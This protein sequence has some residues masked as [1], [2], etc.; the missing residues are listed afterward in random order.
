[1]SKRK[2][3]DYLALSARI[4][5][6]ENRLLTEERM[7]RMIDAKDTEDAAKVLAECGYGALSALTG[8]GVEQMLT[9]AQAALFRELSGDEAARPV[10]EV[11]RCKYD[12]HNAKALVKAAAL[13]MELSQAE[14]ILLPGG[15][16]DTAALMEGFRR[17]EL[18]TYSEIFRKG[19]SQAQ[20]TL[21]ATGD[22]QLA[23]LILDRAYFAELT[24]L[25]KASGS[26]FLQGYAAL[27]IDG[28]NLRSAVRAARLGKGRDFLSQVLLPGGN[29]SPQAVAAADGRGLDGVFRSGALREAA[30]AGATLAAPGSGPLTDFERLCD[31]AVMDYLGGGRR[32]PFGEQPV[33]GYLHAREAEMTAV[34]TI[35]NGRLAGLPG[36]V[37]RR[38]LRRPYA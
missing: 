30:A 23:D 12:Y 32:V 36:E 7:E 5:A 21:G 20:E 26:E 1:M 34:R 15:R 25:A 9:Q 13:G 37:I 16:Y 2:D 10:V 24:A 38:R 35:L 17:G 11:F 8:D 18:N 19:V 33:I 31:D 14:H 22:P 6:M 28:A 4:H 3:T 29:V 27:L